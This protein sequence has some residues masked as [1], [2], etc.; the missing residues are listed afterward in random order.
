MFNDDF[1]RFLYEALKDEPD[2]KSDVHFRK[3]DDVLNN[4]LNNNVS[5]RR[6]RKKYYV[7][8]MIIVGCIIVSFG[9]AYAGVKISIR[10]FSS[11]EEEYIKELNTLLD[12]SKADADSYSRKLTDTENER[13]IEQAKRYESGQFPAH[14]LLYVANTSDVKGNSFCYCYENSMLYLPREELTDEQLLQI[15][16]FYAM[17]DYVL[18]V[19]EETRRQYDDVN[20]ESLSPTVEKHE[21]ISKKKAA[22]IAMGFLENALKEDITGTEVKTKRIKNSEL[23][24]EGMVWEV[25]VFTSDMGKE[26]N[27]F[28]ECGEGKIISYVDLVQTG[29]E[30]RNAACTESDIRE[31]TERILA[32]YEYATNGKKPAKTELS[33]IED[34]DGLVTDGII[35]YFIRNGDN[36]GYIAEVSINSRN[37]SGFNYSDNID[38]YIEAE[39]RYDS[40]INEGSKIKNKRIR[41]NID[42]ITKE[43]Y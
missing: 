14:G 25:S 39:D 30:K 5:T 42:S 15:V 40:Y 10:R 13:L 6:T 8:A 17:R 21:E 38:I 36:S 26:Y 43:Y 31:F 16:D 9:G 23:Y 19:A 22:E 41:R 1:D 35:M 20:A 3:L 32:A 28:A 4:K 29:S 12:S 11:L 37:I 7:A 27:V 2:E 34:G 24:P 33:Y 18:H